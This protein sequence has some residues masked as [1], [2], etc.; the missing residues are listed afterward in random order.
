[1]RHDGD[2]DSNDDGANSYDSGKWMTT[3]VMIVAS[4]C[5]I[6]KVTD[7]T[8]SL[9]YVPGRL[10]HLDTYTQCPMNNSTATQP[11]Q[12]NCRVV[13]SFWRPRW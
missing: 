3:I 11:I 2:D 1:M 10:M 12:A 5:V 6:S 8:E 13:H 9:V 4:G 7:V